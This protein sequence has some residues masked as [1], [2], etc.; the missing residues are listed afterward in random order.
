MTS[1]VN[2]SILGQS[3]LF[4]RGRERREVFGRIAAMRYGYAIGLDI[5]TRHVAAAQARKK[6]KGALVSG[7]FY[8]KLD[9]KEE[10]DET[11]ISMI[12]E[13]RKSGDFKGRNVVLS[14][15]S[16]HLSIFPLRF[17]ADGPA[18]V[19][20]AIV[21]ESE[22]HIPFPLGD[23]ILD[24]PSL[25]AD[26]EG[27]KRYKALVVAMRRQDVDRYLEL[28]KSAGFQVEA[29]DCSVSALIRLHH[30]L[31]GATRN[32]VILV[33]IGRSKSLLVVTTGESVAIQRDINWGSSPLIEQFL[34]NLGEMGDRQNAKA[35]LKRYGLGFEKHGPIRA[36]QEHDADSFA[37][38]R[39]IYQVITPYI[40]ELLHEM[41][42]AISYAR[43]EEHHPVFE[44]IY[45]YGLASFIPSLDTYIEG[46]LNINTEIVD[47]I[48]RIGVTERTV[49]GRVPED[50]PLALA[51][52]LAIRKMRWP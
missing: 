23:A 21:R 44:R 43:V 16:K 27:G 41:D 13:I 7:L 8:Q 11:L 52:G 18:S 47:P 2:Y 10:T 22:K 26:G 3:V 5:G 36:D 40:D 37:A 30:H 12:R 48:E 45:L 32:P 25:S 49:L 33:H 4:H 42:K 24:Y 50:A 38:K 29:F 28:A 46:R 14:V 6:G 1:L 35:I 31:F 39:A 34:K 20:E 17:E 9:K 51:L 15:P 19:E